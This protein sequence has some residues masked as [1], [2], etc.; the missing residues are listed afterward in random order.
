MHK[1]IIYFLTPFLQ[2]NVLF[3][4][5]FEDLF[6]NSLCPVKGCLSVAAH[7]DASPAP[8][9]GGGV[10]SRPTTL[11]MVMPVP[12][13]NSY[14][15]NRNLCGIHNVITEKFMLYTLKVLHL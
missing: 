14:H 11:E 5:S 4:I 3:S 6:S 2:R 13:D 12:C 7:E 9:G 1:H 8:S 15:L 10:C